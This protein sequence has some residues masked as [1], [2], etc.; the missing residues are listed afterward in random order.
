MTIRQLT[1]PEVQHIHRHIL[2][3][4]YL[5]DSQFWGYV[6]GDKIVS[7]LGVCD[8][9]DHWYIH[10]GFTLFEERSK[11]YFDH[12]FVYV[13]DQYKD[14]EIGCICNELS[15]NIVKK[16]LNFDSKLYKYCRK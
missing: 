2:A 9:G 4:S 8:C 5:E 3:L 11:G 15:K 7:F 16:Y 13:I 6:I 1:Q 12:L 14:K 10:S